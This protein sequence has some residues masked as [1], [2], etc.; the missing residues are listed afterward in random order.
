M[1]EPREVVGERGVGPQ[2]R[3]VGAFGGDHIA[4]PRRRG[5]FGVWRLFWQNFGVRGVQEDGGGCRRGCRR[6]HGGFTVRVV[7]R[8]PSQG[9]AVGVPVD[10]RGGNRGAGGDDG[11]AGQRV[12]TAS[13]GGGASARVVERGA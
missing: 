7:G 10:G 9:D 1:A 2:R 4:G 5:G 3:G 8:E 12:P 11:A 6:E 13:H